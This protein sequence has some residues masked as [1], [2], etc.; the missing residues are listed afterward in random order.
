MTHAASGTVMAIPREPFSISADTRQRTSSKN[1]QQARINV[2]SRSK[3][4]LDMDCFSKP[5][6]ANEMSQRSVEPVPG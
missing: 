2:S 4:W 1:A 3:F 5:E 6:N